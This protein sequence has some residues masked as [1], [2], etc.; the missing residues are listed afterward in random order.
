MS[1]K[2]NGEGEGVGVYFKEHSGLSQTIVWLFEVE[3]EYM[4]YNRP[5]LHTGI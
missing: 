1:M 5:K 2:R 3:M 4:W